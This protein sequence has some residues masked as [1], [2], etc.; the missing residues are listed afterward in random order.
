MSYG[1]LYPTSPPGRASWKPIGPK[2][3]LTSSCGAVPS[4]SAIR[5]LAMGAAASR[6][7]I[8]I[9]TGSGSVAAVARLS[10]D[11]HPSPAAFSPLHALKPPGSLSGLAAALCPTLFLGGGDAAVQGPE[12][13]ARSLHASP[14]GPRPGLF[15][16]GAFLPP[17]NACPRRSGGSSLFR[18]ESAAP[19]VRKRVLRARGD[20]AGAV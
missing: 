17:P 4:M 14:L 5:L 12:S 10:E 7:T 2:S 19:C 15:A 11:L 9:T 8:D 20:K 13:L 18:A 3:V 16:T 6:P 1:S